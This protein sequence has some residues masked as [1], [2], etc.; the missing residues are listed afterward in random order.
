MT[1]E[2]IKEKE[3]F[4]KMVKAIAKFNIHKR[5]DNS[6]SNLDKHFISEK[7]NTLNPEVKQNVK[8]EINQEKQRINPERFSRVQII[9]PENL[10]MMPMDLDETSNDFKLNRRK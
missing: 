4:M 8:A 6:I 1:Q 2:Q 10:P 3:L 7:L 9:D 5:G